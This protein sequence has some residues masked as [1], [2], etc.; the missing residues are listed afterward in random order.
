MFLCFNVDQ[1]NQ[2]YAVSRRN[3]E[4]VNDKKPTDAKNVRKVQIKKR[5]VFCEGLDGFPENTIETE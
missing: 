4:A 3:T 2:G 1:W 5:R